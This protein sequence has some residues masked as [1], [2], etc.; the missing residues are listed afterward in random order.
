MITKKS[1]EAKL[2]NK[3]PG[4]FL[5]GLVCASSFALA[6]FEW[7]NLIRLNENRIKDE[8]IIDTINDTEVPKIR[9]YNPQPTPPK[10][11]H[12]TSNNFKQVDKKVEHSK[13]VE[14]VVIDDGTKENIPGSGMPKLVIEKHFYKFPSTMTSFPGGMKAM[15]NFINESTHYPK[16]CRENNMEAKVYVQFIVNKR[17]KVT[18]V[19]VKNKVHPAFEKEAKRV[20][21]K[22]PNWKPG[23]QGA[24]NV[25]VQLTLPIHFSLSE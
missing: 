19:K 9:I 4:L 20:I 1:K 5:L 22:M 24:R 11:Q 25:A 18:N 15:Q 10:P 13:E 2:E 17:G 16:I 12:K 21:S 8:A 7:N 3:R 6:A 14:K 23:K